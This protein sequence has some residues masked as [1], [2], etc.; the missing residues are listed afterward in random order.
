[1]K[2]VDQDTGAAASSWAAEVPAGTAVAAEA[3]VAAEAVDASEA[4]VGAGAGPGAGEVAPT[5]RGPLQP[6]ELATAGVLG[7]MTV[8]LVVA[9]WFVPHASAITA[10]G[11]VPMGVIAYRHRP[12]AVIA[13]VVAAASVGFLVAGT[14]VISTI[15]LYGLIGGLAGH[16]HRRRWG[17]ARVTAAAAVTSPV[18]AAVVIGVLV[19]FSSLRKLTLE[20]LRNTWRGLAGAIGRLIGALP[21]KQALGARVTR[22]MDQAVGAA[23]RDWWQTVGVIVMLFVLFATLVAWRLLDSLFVRLARVHVAD[24][25]AAATPAAAG[26]AAGAGP[27]RL[28]HV[29]VR[30]P[31]AAADALDDVTAQIDAGH[32]VAVL[33]PN[34]SG[35]STLSRVLA[36]CPPTSGAVVRRGGAG[37][38]EPGGTAIV[39]QR[40]ESQVLGVRVADDLV[41][42]LPRD[43]EVDTAALLAAVG[44]SGMEKRE[45]SGLSGGQLQRLAVAAALARRPQ[46]LISDESTA[47]IDADGRHRLVALLSSL[48]RERDMTVVHVTHRLAE[49]AAADQVLRLAAGRVI[50]GVDPAGPGP[51]PDE[52]TPAVRRPGD[53][54]RRP[55][56]AGAVTVRLRDV[57]HVYAQGTPW[58]QAALRHVDLD[59]RRGEGVLV[60]GGNGSGKSTLAWILAGLLRPTSGDC[61]VDGTPVHE[62]IG[63]VGVAFQHARLQVQRAT[64]GR[65]VEQ[66]GHVDRLAAESALRLVGLDPVQLWDRAV[67]ELSGGQLRRVAL[68]GLLTRVPRV[69]V[70]DEPLAGLDDASR[71]GLLAVLADLRANHGLT[72]IVI[73]HDLEGAGEICDRVVRLESGLVVADDVLVDVPAGAA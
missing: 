25:L 2:P 49:T 9:G 66:A 45:T 56:P 13:A 63:T 18:V 19:V 41:W 12:R 54:G 61:E 33:G 44:L 40:P 34:G 69:L 21:G 35:K 17:F 7:A 67:D 55:R 53:D 43:F 15:V 46:L 30:Y 10:L 73:S 23:I 58:A 22:D 5:A 16:A 20:Q 29:H 27:G 32:L 70:L 11:S 26:V 8:V 37:L 28:E 71:V 39:A 38:G 62:Q 64:V 4:A 68:A 50:T 47:M 14:G 48:P 24:R 52:V 42:G 3:R 6:I 51:G 57:G 72:L 59:I 31:G 65:D 1:V 36:G 60:V